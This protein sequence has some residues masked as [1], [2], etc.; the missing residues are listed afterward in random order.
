M[1]FDYHPYAFVSG[2]A[3]WN[4]TPEG[5]C[6]GGGARCLVSCALCVYYAVSSP[7]SK[8]AVICASLQAD[9]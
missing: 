7:E 1:S 4:F 9:L 5:T 8:V 6:L 2:I 3:W